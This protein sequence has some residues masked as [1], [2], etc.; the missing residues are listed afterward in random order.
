[1]SSEIADGITPAGGNDGDIQKQTAML[2]DLRKDLES[3]ADMVNQIESIRGQLE[4]LRPLL[5]NNADARSTADDLDKKL[6]DIEDNLIQRKFTGQGQDTTRFPP[7]LISKIG[8]LAGGVGSG[9]F[10]PNTQQVEV[11]MLFKAQLASLRKRLDD[12]V[13]GDLGG[14]NRMLREKNVGNVVAVSP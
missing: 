7:K 13:S 5:R 9:D 12:V 6:T 2:A 1:M 14:F 8:Y 4:N 3:A 11:Q 10:P